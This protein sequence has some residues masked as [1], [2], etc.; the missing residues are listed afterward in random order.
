MRVFLFL[1]FFFWLLLIGCT[2]IAHQF[3]NGP[4]QWR[5]SQGNKCITVL[6]KKG[7]E[8][9]DVCIGRSLRD[10][11]K[12]LKVVAI[13][14]EPKHLNSNNKCMLYLIRISRGSNTGL[15]GRDKFEVVCS[16]RIKHRI[17]IRR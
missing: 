12:Q 11:C 8:E 17:E 4:R 16:K 15:I 3:H 10:C 5:N 9:L 1:S 13:L 7:F 6:K 2:T 14:Y